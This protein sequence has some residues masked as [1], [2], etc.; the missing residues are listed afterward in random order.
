MSK[1]I[2]PA[3][4]LEATMRGGVKSVRFYSSFDTFAVVLRDG[5]SGQGKT[6]RAAIET[7]S[8]ERKAA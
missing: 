2:D 8:H 1:P 7:A 5:R 6:I 3:D 4:E